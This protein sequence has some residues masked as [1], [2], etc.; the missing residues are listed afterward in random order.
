[1]ITMAAWVFMGGRHKAGHDD[2]GGG[3]TILHVG[4]PVLSPQI[5]L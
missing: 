2:W 1:M 3:N 4:M 5:Q